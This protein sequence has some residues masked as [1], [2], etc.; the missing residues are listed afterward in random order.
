MLGQQLYI[1]IARRF[2]NVMFPAF[3]CAAC[4]LHCDEACALNVCTLGNTT[5]DA[6]FQAKSPT[7]SLFC[8]LRSV[9]GVLHFLCK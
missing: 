6:M 9:L 4:A 3:V 5:S 8:L 7:E 2:S 1:D